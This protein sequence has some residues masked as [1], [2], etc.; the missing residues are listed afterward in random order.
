[1]NIVFEVVVAVVAVAVAV[2]EKSLKEYY[3]QSFVI[4]QW[5]VVLTTIV[6]SLTVPASRSPRRSFSNKSDAATNQI[7]QFSHCDSR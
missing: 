5:A 3:Q 6:H 4:N 2:V 1:M 7:N